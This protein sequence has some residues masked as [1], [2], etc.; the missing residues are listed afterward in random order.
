MVEELNIEEDSLSIGVVNPEAIII[1]EDDGSVV[2]DFDPES[3]ED[4]I[5]FGAN[6]AEH[7]DES[8][9]SILSSDLIASYDDDKASRSDWEDTYIDGLDLLGV[10]IEDRSTPFQGATGVSHP[11]LSEAVI[12][13]V[14]QAM[15][16]IFPSNGPVRTTVIGEKT[17][18]R[19]QQAIRVRDYM[20]YLLTEEIEEYR[21]STEQLLFKTALS[22][23]GFRKVYKD[24]T[25][26]RPDSIFVPAEDFVI[27]Y[28]TT[29]LKSSP[30]Y[31]HVM[32]KSD[33]FVRRM[34]IN[35]FYRDINLGDPSNEGSDIQTKY[36]ELTGVTEVSDTD[37]RTLL[38]MFVELD[39]E[40]FEHTGQDGEPTGLSLPYVV[41]IDQTSDTILSIRRNY[42]EDDPLT[43]PT[44]HFVHYKFQPGLGFYGFGL[45]HLIG[46]IAK[47]STSILRQLI[48]AGTLANLPAGFKARG[49]RIKGDDRPIEPGEFRDIDLPGGA[50]R[51]NILPLPFKEPSPTLAQ[52][53]G[54]LVDE[55][56]RIASIADMNIGEGNQEAPVGT[57]IALIERSM[58]VMSAVHARLHNSLKREFK[59]LTEIIRDTL[60]EYPYDVGEDSLIARSDFD[61]RVDIIP[62]SDP[63]A[64]SFAQRI[65]QQQAA[66]QTSAQAPQL[67]DLRKLHR[68]FLH[69]VGVDG[70]DEIIPDPT[71]V[72]AFD[73]VSENARLMSGA[74]VKVYAYQDHD[75]HISAHMSL[76]QDPSMQQNP[77]AKM[78]QQSVSSHISEH[79]A[80]K[81]RNEA[82]ELMS[83]EL[84]PLNPEAENGLSEEEESRISAQASQAA[85]QITGKAQQQAVLEKQ[86]AAAQ[87]PVMQ[88]QQAELQVKQ[89]KVQQEAQEAQ[90]DAQVEMQKAQMR[91]QLERERL[92]QQR[93][94]AEMKAQIE[95]IKAGMKTN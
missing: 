46:S 82:Q 39:L 34:Q 12:R 21:P 11:I 71:D 24:E 49:L 72:P 67:Y 87:D 37:V 81:Y 41:T 40:G 3:S 36:N 18:E 38:E 64:T 10:K 27:S 92:A 32:R 85:A 42:K 65:M 68:A 26:N 75:S 74:A 28:E 19:D 76:M 53:M 80:H 63:N 58:K 29:D 44:Q 78:I 20:N 48:D 91:T 69:T 31:T 86:M 33:N 35:G 70:V 84:P 57:T 2:I 93:E 59:L 95:L 90:M 6:L 7:I 88:Q 13:F 5:E 14:S 60:P 15:M 56:R 50:I 9:L 89:A 25:H 22:G 17:L 8:E 94:I 30:R 62:V 66:L 45:I 23:S 51:D 83:E 52:L 1:G 61:D 47:S 54:V 77:M 4:K 73:P 79:M 16:E 43:E 55:G